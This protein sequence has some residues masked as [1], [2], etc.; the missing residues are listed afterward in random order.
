MKHCKLFL[1]FLLVVLS[2]I[3]CSNAQV[4]D[5]PDANFKSALLAHNPVIDTDGDNQIQFSEAEVVTYLNVASKNI[6]SMQGVESFSN[7]EDLN[8]DFNQLTT[9]DLEGLTNLTVLSCSFNQ[10]NSINFNGLVNLLAI[11]CESNELKSLD[12]SSL[13]NLVQ[14]DCSDNQFVTLDFNNNPLSVL[15]CAGN[16]GLTSILLKNGVSTSFSV[17]PAPPA[18]YLGG[19]PNLS[20][21][22]VDPGSDAENILDHLAILGYSECVVTTDCSIIDDPVITFVDSNFKNALIKDGIDTNSDGE[23]QVLEALSVTYLNIGQENINDLTGI[24]YFLNL[25]SLTCYYNDLSEVNLNNNSKLTHLNCGDNKLASLLIDG[26]KDLIRLDCAGNLL[27]NLN[28]TENLNLEYILCSNNNLTSLSNASVNLKTLYCSNN[29]LTTFD[30]NQNVN[31]ELLDCSNNKLINLTTTFNDKISGL[32]CD[33]NPL[34]GL[35]LSQNSNLFYLRCSSTSINSLDFSQNALIKTVECK[36]GKLQELIFNNNASLYSLKCANNQITSLE[37]GNIPNITHLDLNNNSLENLNINH[38]INNALSLLAEGNPNLYCI[39]V[40]DPNTFR[41]DNKV[42]LDPQVNMNIDCSAD[43]DSDGVENNSDHCINTLEGVSVDENGCSNDEN[44]DDDADGVKNGIDKCPNTESGESV[45]AFGCPLSEIVSIPDVNFK[46]YLV[47]MNCY[48]SDND[49]IPDILVDSNGDGDIQISEA[50]GIDN[51]IFPQ[52][53]QNY[54]HFL[55]LTGIDHFL[56]L[57]KLDFGYVQFYGYAPDDFSL[58]DYSSSS[59]DFTPLVLL[60][61]LKLY[62]LDTNVVKNVDLSGLVNLDHLDL[63]NNKGVDFSG[64]NPQF[65]TINLEGCTSL[66]TLIFSNSFLRFDY[67]QA[68]NLTYLDCHYLEGGEPEFF[69]FSCLVNLE[70]LDISENLIDKLMLKNGSVLNNIIYN[71]IGNEPGSYLPFPNYICIDDI[72]EEYDM[73]S[74][75]I[76]P[77]TTVNSYCSNTPGGEY[78][79]VEGTN[80]I[81]SDGNGCD[82]ADPIFPVLKFRVSDGVIEGD[83]ISDDSGDYNISLQLGEHIIT[84]LLEH[85]E[86]FTVSPSSITVDFSTDVSPYNQ[87]FCLTP[88]PG[89]NDLE[90]VIIPITI[91]QPG[92]DAKYK[93]VYKNKGS[94]VLS[95]SVVVLFQDD[96]MD[97]VSSNPMVDGQISGELTWNFNDLYPFE[98]RELLFTMNINTTLE[99]PPVNNGDILSFTTTINPTLDDETPNDNEFTLNQTVVNSY[100]PNDKTCLEGY[101]I[102]PDLVGEYVHYLIRCENTGT[103]EAVNIV[104][105]D[106][107]DTTKFDISTLFVTDASHSMETRINE[108]EVEF[109]F[110]NIYL[111]FDDANN[112]GYVAFKIKTLPTLQVGDLFENDAEIFFDYNAPIETNVAQTSIEDSLGIDE[113]RDSNDSIKMFP[114][115]SKDKVYIEFNEVIESVAI[116][117]VSGKMIQSKSFVGINQYKVEIPVQ[118]LTEGTYFIKVNSSSGYNYKKL[119]KY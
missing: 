28:L 48:D 114:N 24:E 50:T 109:V 65:A 85:P 99:M 30:I 115:P 53:V 22:C 57:I 104:I 25:E 102:T 6:T 7:L 90:V 32:Y 58:L 18:S 16:I 82:I 110:E 73:L 71:Y 86:Y 62:G 9:L 66:K 97:L 93:I 103:A 111:P 101:T 74:G 51:L 5:I 31:L 116:Y 49:D 91:A 34:I 11:F 84:P 61:Y 33:D 42:F 4:V 21:I 41:S 1:A 37:T 83:F 19:C 8:C 2:S 38:T 15:A 77:D 55:D 79:V 13:I 59:M 52:S 56:N 88:I 92:F 43:D 107:I 100:D 45:N 96:I 27:T 68:P 95:G 40:N 117:T 81:D 12:F 20:F 94:S 63:S 23:I 46:R 106:V 44:L 78:F 10:L 70:V 105:K 119:V 72:Q 80:R 60:E 112:D 64:E 35:D 108:S 113:F 67:C 14:V 17:P 118:K 39:Q 89:F 36:D 69:D 3:V 47:N 87:D 54:S 26:C 98:S 75:L 76:G 29:D